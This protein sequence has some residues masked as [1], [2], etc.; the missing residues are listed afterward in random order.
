[1]RSVDADHMLRDPRL[2]DVIDEHPDP[3]LAG[4]SASRRQPNA[5]ALFHGGAGTV[6]PPISEPS[7]RNRSGDRRIDC[8][9]QGHARGKQ[10]GLSEEELAFFDAL[11]T[12]DSAVK[13]L[14]EPTLQ[15]IARELVATVRKN[16]TIDCTLRENVRAQ[17]RVLV[18]R[19]LRKYGYPPDK[20]ERATQTVLEQAALLS[21]ACR[22]LNTSRTRAGS[23]PLISSSGARK[24]ANCRTGNNLSN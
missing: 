7:D 12:N 24:P 13:V 22:P 9:C 20:Q 6:D 19:I 14:G 3:V 11:E 21:E 16:V 8:A 5:G 15:S 4:S 23:A 2:I 18:R 1:M 17:T 10:L